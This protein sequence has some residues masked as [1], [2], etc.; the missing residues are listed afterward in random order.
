MANQPDPNILTGQ[1][2]PSNSVV[3]PQGGMTYPVM[4]PADPTG[5][6]AMGCSTLLA[7]PSAAYS[8][9]STLNPSVFSTQYINATTL[10]ISITASSGGTNPTV[11]FFYDRQG[12][13]GVW[14]N[15][16]ST[17]ATVPTVTYSIDVGPF[18]VTYGGTNTAQ[19]N[20]FT[21]SARLRWTTSQPST[22]T[23]SAS[24]VGR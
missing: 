3:S 16:L 8:T 14:Y 22:I 24:V 5:K 17:P 4:A 9:A 12:A 15:I 2:G 1:P 7:I 11:T 13:D 6:L 19:H 23:F 10:D 18:S 20:V 21:Q